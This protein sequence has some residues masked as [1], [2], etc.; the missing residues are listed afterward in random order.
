MPV[1]TRLCGA[2]GFQVRVVARECW[3]GGFFC[4]KHGRRRTARFRVLLRA[5]RVTIRSR[6]EY[7]AM[8]KLVISREE[9]K[10]RREWLESMPAP[11]APRPEYWR[12]K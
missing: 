9:E 3:C 4:G 6:S 1:G 5:P 10:L 12:R 2:V 7:E 11:V 8:V